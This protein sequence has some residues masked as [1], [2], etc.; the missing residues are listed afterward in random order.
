MVKVPFNLEHWQKVA[1]E[2]YPNGLPEP[3]SDD[4][5]QWIFHGHPAVSTSPLQV[6]V[7]RLLGYRWPAELD[8]SMRL[9]PEARELV[10]RCREL[11]DYA[12]S[13]GIVC[14]PSVRGEDRL[15]NAFGRCSP[16]HKGIDW[17]PTKEQELIAA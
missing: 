10:Q 13:D 6:A 2:K 14:I 9:S 11:E 3:Y 8:D 5:T 1:A 17:S 4:P 12:D 7:A 16:P 15:L